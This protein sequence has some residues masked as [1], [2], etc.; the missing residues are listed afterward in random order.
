MQDRRRVEAG[1]ENGID[2]LLRAYG[3]MGSLNDVV[4]RPVNGHQVTADDIGPANDRLAKL[5]SRTYEAATRLKIELARNHG[6]S[7][8]D[9][10]LQDDA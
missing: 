4:I 5:S 7:G 6:A 1:D 10:G 3:G 9:L 8:G 2:H